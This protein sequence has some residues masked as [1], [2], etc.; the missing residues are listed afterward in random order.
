[1]TIKDRR[2]QIR[3]TTE[4]LEGIG[5]RAKAAGMS[6]AEYGRSVLLA[7]NNPILVKQES[8][9]DAPEID[10]LGPDPNDMDG[11]K[12]GPLDAEGDGPNYAKTEC[13]VEGVPPGVRCIKCGEL[14]GS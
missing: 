3:V 7:D 13:D 1:M 9:L 4:E 10:Y 12:W 11:E 8:L 2:L 5:R 6:V 14:H